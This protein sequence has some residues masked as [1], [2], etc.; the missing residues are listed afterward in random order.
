MKFRFLGTGTSQGVPL[1]GC[2]CEVCTSRDSR[3]KRFRTAAVLESS[4]TRLLIDCGPDIRMQLMQVPFRKID[5]LLLTHE[6]YDHVG[7]L[8]DLRP[9]C[10]PFGNLDIYANEKTIEAVRHNLPYCF[11]EHPYPGVPK[12]NLHVVSKHEAFTVGDIDILPVE[13]MHDRLPILGYRFGDFAY[14]TDMKAIDESELSYL[15][16]VKT[17]VVNALRWEKPHHSHMLVKEAIAFSEKVGARR[18]FFVH[19]THKI[20]LYDEA[21]SRLPEGF[22]IAYD[23]QEIEV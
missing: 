12:F 17:L 16:G 14:I 19:V 9:F 18:T 6:H 23:G 22:E 7:G 11:D 2:R 4:T 5:G 8:D 20:G 13:V 1:V 3:D 10:M 21:N 15:K